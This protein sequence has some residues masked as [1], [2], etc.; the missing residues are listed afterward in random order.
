MTNEEAAEVA[1]EGVVEFHADR[2][3]RASGSALGYYTLPKV[4]QKILEA[5]RDAMDDH[6]HA[7]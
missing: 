4:R 3:L 1:R 2:I 5:V 6:L 7:D